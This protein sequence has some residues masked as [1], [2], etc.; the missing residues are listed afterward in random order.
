MDV[1]PG[2]RVLSML[3]LACWVAGI[4]AVMW[5][6]LRCN[7]Y[8]IRHH[9][10][11]DPYKMPLVALPISY[12]PLDSFVSYVATLTLLWPVCTRCCGA[13]ARGGSS[14]VQDAPPPV[15]FIE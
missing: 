13:L 12:G 9:V 1:S 15:E 4:A 10:H 6:A 8:I 3:C 11:P 5:F 14:K 2:R 7:E